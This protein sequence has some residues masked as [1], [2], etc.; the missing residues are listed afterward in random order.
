MRSW[1]QQWLLVICLMVVPA[2]VSGSESPQQV[3]LPSG[4]SVSVDQIDAD[5][6]KGME[7][8]L[9]RVIPDTYSRAE[10]TFAPEIW[11]MAAILAMVGG[12]DW[13]L[14]ADSKPGQFCP[15]F[16][17][18]LQAWNGIE[19][20]EPIAR[21]NSFGHENF[22]PIREACPRMEPHLVILYSGVEQLAGYGIRAFKWFKLPG[23]DGEMTD[24][25]T[26]DGVASKRF[27]GEIDR[28]GNRLKGPIMDGGTMAVG[29]GATLFDPKLVRRD[30]CVCR[31]C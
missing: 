7:R 11:K 22:R 16:L 31:P 12:V 3:V 28:M 5:W 25:L 4:S 14:D 13:A 1:S 19:V 27:P 2:T 6:L 20:V 29:E 8:S 24:M 10:L 26:F 9:R 30:N 23:P 18:G 17:S 15:T 21:A